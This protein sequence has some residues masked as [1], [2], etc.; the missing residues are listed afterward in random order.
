MVWQENT[1]TEEQG[2]TKKEKMKDVINEEFNQF[3][4]NTTA[5]GIGNAARTELTISVRLVWLC[6][7][8]A[9][10]TANAYHLSTIISEYLSYP[11][12]EARTITSN[13]IRFPYVTVCN[14][15]PISQSA[16]IE[17]SLNPNSSLNQYIGEYM[18]KLEELNAFEN[19]TGIA[20]ADLLESP[21]GI[22]SNLN[23]EDLI[24]L[25]HSRENFILSC[26]YRSAPC[27]MVND[28]QMFTSAD[29][30][31]CYTFT[32][33]VSAA[34]KPAQPEPASGLSLIL[35]MENVI[36]GLDSSNVGKYNAFSSSQNSNGLRVHV[37][38]NGTLPMPMAGGFDVLPGYSTSVSLK[39]E[40]VTKLDEPYGECTSNSS[41]WGASQYAYSHE[42]C[43]EICLVNFVF[44]HCGCIDKNYYIPSYIPLDSNDYCF[45]FSVDFDLFVARLECISEKALEFASSSSVKA[46][47]RCEEP[48]EMYQ[49]D[50]T[51]SQSRWPGRLYISDM[52]TKYVM[53]HEN[54]ANLTA[55]QQLLQEFQDVNRSS[56]FRQLVYENFAR[57][58]VYF[59]NTNL[60]EIS[61]KPSYSFGNL[62]SN[63][64]GTIGLWAGLS[65]ITVIEVTFFL[66]RLCY[67]CYKN[68]KYKKSA[69]VVP[70]DR[71][72]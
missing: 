23:T 72:L 64:G 58:N 15:E 8:V 43:L 37:H 48:C 34:A 33:E 47:C 28:F 24:Y 27:D 55:Y 39:S 14:Q 62:W 51:I 46:S 1:F 40:R 21:T 56:D 20:I 50:V 44:E 69:K 65:V 45:K 16:A 22:G 57:L 13:Y 9:A 11:S 60:H 61:Q 26:T 63:I 29:Y 2:D 31:N 49:Y 70:Q 53:K 54:A 71:V 5:H 68:R 6:V 42:A 12:Q 67:L 4:L 19:A 35:Y 41:L 17:M 66:I 7:F 10:L 52:Y 36:D 25:G 3:C 38:E 59:Q 32:G 18:A 30:Y